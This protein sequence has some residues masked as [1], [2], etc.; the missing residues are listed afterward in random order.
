MLT[1]MVRLL[2]A[3]HAR[4]RWFGRE[5]LRARTGTY[6]F[7]AHCSSSS[8]GAGGAPGGGGL[9]TGSNNGPCAFVPLAQQASN[10]STGEAGGRVAGLG[11]G[12]KPLP[13]ASGW[14]LVHNE[15]EDESL[16]K[17]APSAFPRYDPCKENFTVRSLP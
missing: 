14:Q 11:V 6:S 12:S 4:P 3:A 2:E 7:P 10:R 8:A 15:L 9:G 1:T 17:A 16:H 5:P 13:R